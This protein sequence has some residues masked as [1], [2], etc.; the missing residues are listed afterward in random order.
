MATNLLLVGIASGAAV[1]AL[2]NYLLLRFAAAAMPIAM[3]AR[4]R[5]IADSLAQEIPGKVAELLSD[6]AMRRRST[7]AMT[8]QLGQLGNGLALTVDGKHLHVSF[9]RKCQM[10]P[11]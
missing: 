5:A 7:L 2:S 4:S 3:R 1:G 6:P 11:P 9:E 8:E 10:S